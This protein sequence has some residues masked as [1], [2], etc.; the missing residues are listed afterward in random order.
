MHS[1]SIKSFDSRQVVSL[2]IAQMVE[3]ETV[4]L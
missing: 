2:V 3:R 4:D 1:I